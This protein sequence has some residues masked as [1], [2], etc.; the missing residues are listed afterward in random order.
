[1]PSPLN[2]AACRSSMR[3]GRLD[4]V[5]LAGLLASLDLLVTGDTGPMHLASAVDT[6]LVALFGPSDPRRYGPTSPRQRIL[7]V[8]LPCSPCGQVRLPPERCRGHVPGLHGRHPGGPRSSPRP[9]S[10]WTTRR[11]VRAH[12]RATRWPPRITCTHRR[13]ATSSPISHRCSRRSCASRRAWTPI[14]WIKQLRLVPYDG[15]PM[16]ERFLYRGDSLWWFTELYLHK[17]RRLD[18]AVA[19]VLALETA[20]R[21]APAVADAPGVTGS[22]TVRAARR[23]VLR[24]ARPSRSTSTGRRT[25][26]AAAR[27]A[28]LSDRPDRAAVAPAPVRAAGRSAPG[29]RG[30]RAHGVLA[31]RA[32]RRSARSR[33]ATSAPCST[34]STAGRRDGDLFCVGVGPRR[35]FRARRWWDPRD[36][37][38]AHSRLVTPVERLAPRAA[39]AGQLRRCGATAMTLARDLTA[40]DGIRAAAVYRGCD[41]WPVLRPELEASPC[42]SGRGPRARWTKPA[43]R[44]TR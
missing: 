11:R 36:G 22:P 8:D 9:R 43:P 42:C 30:V 18:T 33:K 7:R 32:R 12:W 23:G 26:G 14:R 21:R 29:R 37:P 31:R 15:V 4:L 28:E 41:L 17:M 10:C 34:R 38:A 6:P 3:P 25:S 1:M 13:A 5:E 40:G 16:R 2:W 44:S 27:L 19:T 20:H 39:L 24:G 35:N